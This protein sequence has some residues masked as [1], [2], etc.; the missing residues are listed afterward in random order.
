MTNLVKIG[1]SHG[2]R[3]PKLIIEQARLNH[4]KLHLKVVDEG[5]LITPEIRPRANWTAQVEKLDAQAQDEPCL[6]AHLT[7]GELLEW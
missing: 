6:D 2:V 7:N 1:N 4:G 5:L 3:I